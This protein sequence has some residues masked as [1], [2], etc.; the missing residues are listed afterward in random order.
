MFGVHVPIGFGGRRFDRGAASSRFGWRAQARQ[1][2]VRELPGAAQRAPRGTAKPD[3]EWLLEGLGLNRDVLITEA[4]TSVGDR[5]LGP[6]AAR[7][8]Q[9]L[10]DISA[11]LLHWYRKAWSSKRSVKPGTNTSSNRPLE[12]RSIVASSLAMRI[13][14][15]PVTVIVVPSFSFFVKPAANANP[16]SGSTTAEVR[17]SDSHN[18]S[19]PSRSMSCT[20]VT[21]DCWSEA[22]P[23]GVQHQSGL[24]FAYARLHCAGLR[25]GLEAPG[26]VRA[27]FPE[28]RTPREFDLWGVLKRSGLVFD[29]D[30][31]A[32][33]V[34]VDE[35][36]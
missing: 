10:F 33:A 21:N 15:R 9:D 24:S 11:A 13:G 3:L 17:T 19:K 36:V 4:R 28:A 7:E 6:Q 18:E 2:A 12:S 14:L 16:A 35:E 20:A 30:R 8:G 23:G 31:A 27:N 25:L 26:A 5:I 29:D 22:P 34:G 1:P 32:E